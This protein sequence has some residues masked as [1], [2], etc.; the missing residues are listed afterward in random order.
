MSEKKV[1]CPLC[2]SNNCFEEEYPRSQAKNA[3]MIQSWMCMRCGYTSTSA[4]KKH[5]KALREVLKTSPK[6]VVDLKKWDDERNIY[7][8]PAIVTIMSKGMLHPDG[9]VDSWQWKYI[10]VVPIEDSEKEKYRIPGTEGD[11]E[12]CFLKNRF[13]VEQAQTFEKED[14]SSALKAMGAIVEL[15][16]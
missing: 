6:L 12:N 8:F 13:A 2:D 15:P 14:F 5:S 16:C 1:Q 11:G 10:P 3:P 9:E 7:W 4:N